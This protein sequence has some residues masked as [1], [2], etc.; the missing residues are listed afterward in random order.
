M[1]DRVAVNSDSLHTMLLRLRHLGAHAS[2]DAPNADVI[3]GHPVTR[4]FEDWDYL[5]V[6][7]LKTDSGRESRL[8]STLTLRKY[9][10]GRQKE[11]LYGQIKAENQEIENTNANKS[12]LTSTIRTT[13]E[14]K[15]LENALKAE[16]G[17]C[18]NL[19]DDPQNDGI[20]MIWNQ[21]EFEAWCD[22]NEGRRMYKF[23]VDK[24]RL[25][26]RQAEEGERR[27]K[28][29]R[30]SNYLEI[31]KVMTEIVDYLTDH[32]STFI[33]DKVLRRYENP[34]SYEW[35]SKKGEMLETCPMETGQ[36]YFERIQTNPQLLRTARQSWEDEY[37]SYKDALKWRQARLDAAEKD[38]HLHL[39][40]QAVFL[41]EY[42]EK[43]P[44]P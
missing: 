20:Y 22:P 8:Y 39:P 41:Q 37:W 16:E 42:K 14:L 3:Q 44:N 11:L 2:T 31:H 29:Q 36:D 35:W 5:V 33:I 19:Q 10:S 17:R 43:Y 38:R 9:L 13:P 40:E 23:L 21:G 27:T 15:R 32:D 7:K 12:F 6:D 30:P 4:A 28:R 1:L 18:D 34:E 24:D 26:Q 25:T